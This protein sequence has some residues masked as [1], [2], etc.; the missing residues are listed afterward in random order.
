MLNSWSYTIYSAFFRMIT[1]TIF[2]SWKA[3][4]MISSSFKYNY[5]SERILSTN[6]WSDLNLTWYFVMLNRSFY[7]LL[8][9]D[10]IN[11][12]IYCDRLILNSWQQMSNVKFA[13]IHTKFSQAKV[14]QRRSMWVICFSSEYVSNFW[15][16]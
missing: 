5:V 3:C 11:E 16:L 12:F 6:G 13:K 1:M 2:A 8:L 10:C 15:K 7:V 14:F 9:V 4:Q